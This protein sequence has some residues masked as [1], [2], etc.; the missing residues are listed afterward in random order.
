MSIK[1]FSRTIEPKP[2][3]EKQPSLIFGKPLV[4]NLLDI[5]TG[6]IS[7]DQRQ[8][9]ASFRSLITLLI[10]GVLFNNDEDDA[11]F[12]RS[13]RYFL[14]RLKSISDNTDYDHGEF[15]D[16]CKKLSQQLKSEANIIE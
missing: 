11:K 7:L 1:K 14:V 16:K 9:K 4:I 15:I 5:Y 10:H 13:L 3:Q 8:M 6:E 12:I 2:K